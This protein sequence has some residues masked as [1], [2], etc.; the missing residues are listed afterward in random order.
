MA[1]QRE[2]LLTAFGHEIG[3]G[4]VFLSCSVEENTYYALAADVALDRQNKGVLIEDS[5]DYRLVVFDAQSGIVSRKWCKQAWDS[6][7]YS[8][9]LWWVDD[10]LSKAFALMV[11]TLFLRAGTCEHVRLHERLQGSV[12]LSRNDFLACVPERVNWSYFG[13]VNLESYGAL[14]WSSS[15]KYVLEDWTRRIFSK[16]VFAL[17]RGEIAVHAC[18]RARQAKGIAEAEGLRDVVAMGVRDSSSGSLFFR[19]NKGEREYVLKL[20]CLMSESSIAA[21]RAASSRIRNKAPE[22]GVLLCDESRLEGQYVITRFVNGASV[23]DYLSTSTA[24]AE[25]LDGLFLFLLEAVD[26]LYQA[27]I[28]HRDIREA[29]IFVDA[30]GE[31][32]RFSLGDFGC[33]VVMD[34]EPV[35]LRT[36]EVLEQRDIG[37]D[38][39]AG[40]NCWDDAASAY[41]IYTSCRERFGYQNDKVAREIERRIGR[42]VIRWSR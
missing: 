19:A 23:A 22:Q 40:N 17:R 25:F 33:S 28:C 38:R 21:E 14:S 30:P 39:R 13:Y 6:R 7:Y 27:R 32:P 10:R 1:A 42:L 35:S 9:G 24:T 8:D 34:A 11:G 3:D 5:D 41:L 20:S 31:V 18:E 15:A 36:F 2:A 37:D 12:G 29:N 16:V 4:K 26:V